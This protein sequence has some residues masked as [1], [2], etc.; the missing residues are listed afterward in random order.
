VVLAVLAGTSTISGFD[1]AWFS[2]LSSECLMVLYMY[3]KLFWLHPFL[4]LELSMMGL[5]LDL[6]NSPLSFSAM[7]LLVGSSDL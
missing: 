1:L 5:A 7:T 2:S 6:V 4:H 3:S